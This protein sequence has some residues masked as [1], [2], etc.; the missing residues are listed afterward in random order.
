M[1]NITNPD[2]IGESPTPDTQQPLGETERMLSLISDKLDTIIYLL[3]EPDRKDKARKEQ[4]RRASVAT[5]V[6][7]R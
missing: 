4:E 7:V 5:G 2:S 3:Q 1:N 6:N